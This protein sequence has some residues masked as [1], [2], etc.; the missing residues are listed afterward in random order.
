MVLPYALAVVMR[1]YTHV[2]KSDVYAIHARQQ[3]RVFKTTALF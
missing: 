1:D 2:T 3:R